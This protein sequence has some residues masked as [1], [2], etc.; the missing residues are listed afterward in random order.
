[1]STAA[2]RS[3]WVG[4][5]IDGRFALLQWLGGSERSGVF[6]TELQGQP[7]QRAAIKL[8]SADAADAEACIAGW[9]VTT[10]LA[11]PH[12]MRLLYTGR[13][14]IDSTPLVYAVTEYAEEVLSQILPLRPLTPTEAKEML[15]PV[16]DALSYLHGKG[17]VHG[18]LKPSNIMVVDNQLKLS[19]DG[20]NLAGGPGKYSSSLSVYD[21]PEATSEPIS[22]AADVWSLG[23][24]LIEAL[25]QHPPVW[26]RSTQ[27]M[28]IVP[29]FVPPPFAG[30][31][32]G[33]LRSTPGRR[34]ALSDVKARLEP[35]PSLRAP[36]NKTGKAVP[37]KLRVTAFVASVLVLI[38]VAATLLVRSHHVEPSYPNGKKPALNIPAPPPQSPGPGTQFSKGV[39]AKG[40]VAERVLPD[41]F[42]SAR[43]SI[44]GHIRVRI[45]VT[46]DSRGDVSNATFESPGPSKYFARVALQAAQHWRFKPAQVDGQAASSVWILQFQFTQTATEVTPVEVSP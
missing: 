15:D 26:D 36:A 30:I 33:C 1:M 46:V 19:C 5:V 12:L 13:F 38:A 27:R 42:P 2:V 37:T 22:P 17:I 3:D 31:A 40:A 24:T 8:I 16:L 23:V 32:Q 44:R 39:L 11:H 7:S 41:I 28:P 45:R 6:L 34:C 43:E 25:T 4:R 20:L 14:Q 9:A 35:A 21:A 18:H 29:E 10:P